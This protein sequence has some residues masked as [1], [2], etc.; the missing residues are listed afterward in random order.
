MRAKPR[1]HWGLIQ[2]NDL[3]EMVA[4]YAPLEENSCTIENETVKLYFCSA[5][6]A[7]EFMEALA[8]LI[9]HH[10]RDDG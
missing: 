3:A 6:H 4:K 9:E 10:R 2:M 1:K 5:S 8:A 7:A